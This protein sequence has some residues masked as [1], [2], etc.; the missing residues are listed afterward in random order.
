MDPR[1]AWLAA[2]VLVFA[3]GCNS[4]APEMTAGTGSA[5]VQRI[6][7]LAP[8]LAELVFSAGAGERLVGVVEFS[9]FPPAVLALPRVGDAFRVDYE[10]VVA[11][12]PDLVIA[13]TSGNPPEIVQRL[14]TLGLR[15]LSLD[16]VTLDDI[17]GHIAEIGALAG[18]SAIAEEAASRYASRLATLRAAAP[19]GAGVR[20]F[21]QLS[22]RPFFTVT[23][24]HVIGQALRLCG[25]R[26]VFGDLPGLT[27]VVSLESIIEAAPQAIVASD[28]GGA[29]PSPL[30][31][32]QAWRTLPAVRDG[33]LYSLDADLLSRPGARILDAIEQL[34]DKLASG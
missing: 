11:L 15:V 16:P 19:A 34:C 31:S 10:A 23:D 28:M 5:P 8:H 9:D 6:V 33:R 17:G 21:V 2:V 24:R 29:A 1:R 30:A 22:A 14:R 20:V 3:G 18:T 13:W 12:H 32:W 4:P 25:G 26:N 7:T 27:A